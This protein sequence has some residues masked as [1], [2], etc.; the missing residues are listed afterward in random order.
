[1][2]YSFLACKQ[3]IWAVIAT[4]ES[5]LSKHSSLWLNMIIVYVICWLYWSIICPSALWLS[6]VVWIQGRIEISLG[7][8]C[9]VCWYHPL[10]IIHSFLCTLFP[11]I[12]TYSPIL[13]TGVTTFVS[14][15]LM[16]TCT[17]TRALDVDNH[18]GAS[19]VS[20]SFF[21]ATQRHSLFPGCTVSR[22]LFTFDLF[23]GLSLC[24]SIQDARFL[25][26]VLNSSNPILILPRYWHLYSRGYTSPGKIQVHHSNK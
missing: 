10:A 22:I 12:L 23:Y 21:T 20:K 11:T 25:F 13:F 7:I 5:T 26:D 14:H 24:L 15:T 3:R 17:C 1:M 16:Y 9:A 18:V 2:A 19:S 6:Q 8:R 4:V